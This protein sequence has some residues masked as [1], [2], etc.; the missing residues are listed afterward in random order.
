MVEGKVKCKNCSK[1][2]V[3][4]VKGLKFG[5]RKTLDSVKLL[6]CFLDEAYFKFNCPFCNEPS[7][8]GIVFF[9]DEPPKFSLIIEKPTYIG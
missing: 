5:A 3:I 2:Y 1:I 6:N 4:E 8:V 7:I 9:R